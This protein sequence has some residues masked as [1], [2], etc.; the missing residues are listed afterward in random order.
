MMFWVVK[1]RSRIETRG[2]GR[3]ERRGSSGP[4]LGSLVWGVGA[5]AGAGA[6]TESSAA[7]A[8]ERF[9]PLPPLP[10]ALGAA[11]LTTAVRRAALR[12]VA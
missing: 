8:F 10:G 5:A 2:P 11:F 12:E 3:R 4:Q 6:A 1:T 9:F 7:W